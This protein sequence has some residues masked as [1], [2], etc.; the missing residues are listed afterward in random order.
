MVMQESQEMENHVDPA[1]PAVLPQNRDCYSPLGLFEKFMVETPFN[2]LPDPDPDVQFVSVLK[3]PHLKWQTEHSVD[4][5][6][7]K[8]V[9]ALT[10]NNNTLA[11]KIRWMMSR[12]KTKRDD[13]TCKLLGYWNA[14]SKEVQVLDELESC[15]DQTGQGDHILIQDEDDGDI[16]RE[17]DREQSEADLTALL[18]TRQT[19]DH[20]LVSARAASLK[21]SPQKRKSKERR[22]KRTKTL[23]SLVLA[24]GKSPKDIR[25]TTVQT[26][27]D[28]LLKRVL[29]T[30][31]LDV[32]LETLEKLAENVENEIYNLYNDTGVRYKNKYRSLLFNLKDPKNKILFHRVILGELTPQCLVQLNPTE[33]AGLE[34]TNW[35][36]QE[37]Q[38]T[39]EIIERAE[40]ELH[41]KQQMTKLTHKG[42]IEIDTAPDQMF[43]LEDLSDSPWYR[44]DCANSDKS[45]INTTANHKSHL[46]DVNC[47]ICMGKI[48]PSDE[49]DLSQLIQLT[50]PVKITSENNSMDNL[51]SQ[52]GETTEN[53]KK[54]AVSTE[55]QGIPSSCSAV[56]K[57]FINMFSIKQFKVT[58]YKVS[59]YNTHLCQELP[60][61]ITNNGLI[62]P[63]SVWEFMDLI[64]PE[65]TKDMCLLRFCPQTSSDSVFCSRLYSYLNR[66]LK[67]GIVSADNMEAFVIPLPACQPIPHRLHP[68]GGPGLDD[69][70]PQLL[71]GL[72]LPNHPSWTSCTKRSRIQKEELDVPDDIFLSII[73]DMEREEHQ[74]EEQGLPPMWLPPKDQSSVGQEVSMP[75]L[76]GSLC[77]L[78]NTLQGMA[79]QNNNNFSNVMT[80]NQPDPLTATSPMWPIHNMTP[81]VQPLPPYDTNPVAMSDPSVMCGQPCFWPSTF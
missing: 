29:E 25:S 6:I 68:L 38:H 16:M 14:D 40:K 43:T 49:M 10:L 26:L 58:A 39:L 71:L 64:W 41:H 11:D 52:S 74:M 62:C 34:L 65:C 12:V 81:S 28:V 63:E 73:D 19:R 4:S 27:Y 76:I 2:T 72:L 56:W 33:M 17:E 55:L 36:N 69:D 70:H 47:L 1:N 24:S 13:Q 45:E 57:G 31:N 75:E 59:G 61:I 30:Q 37:R 15:S 48:Q 8:N 78:V 3:S 35:R 54:Y 5:H 21:V 7:S 46:L 9:N 23:S 77:L 50:S 22:C 42:L 67:Y 79:T 51:S 60:K 80:D 44:Q 66:K 53:L 20:L 32:H 18:D